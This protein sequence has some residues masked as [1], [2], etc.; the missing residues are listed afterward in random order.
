MVVVTLYDVNL[1]GH[2]YCSSNSICS[3]EG[4][5]FST[6][7]IDC[8]QGNNMPNDLSSQ[9]VPYPAFIHANLA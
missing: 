7:T 1:G 9:E 5:D 3:D 4:D 8:I 2:G 6:A